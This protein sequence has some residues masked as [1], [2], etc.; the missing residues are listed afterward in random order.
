MAEQHETAKA[1]IAIARDIHLHAMLGACATV[2]TALKI[3][4]PPSSR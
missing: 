2:L 1:W 3:V 4:F